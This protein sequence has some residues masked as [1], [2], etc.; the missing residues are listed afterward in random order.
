M[1]LALNYTFTPN[2]IRTFTV[3]VE[4]SFQVRVVVKVKKFSILSDMAPTLVR[5][6]LLSLF[7]HLV[8]FILR[9][10]YFGPDNATLILPVFSTH[11][12]LGRH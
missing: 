4:L 3:T 2:Q 12:L 1:I 11:M 9:G 7:C 8:S 6:A 10:Q 5:R